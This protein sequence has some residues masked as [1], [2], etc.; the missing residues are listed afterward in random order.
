ML[1]THLECGK[2]WILNL[3]WTMCRNFD[4]E[5]FHIDLQRFTVR[6][7]HSGSS[8]LDWSLN[9]NASIFWLWVQHECWFLLFIN[10]IRWLGYLFT[11]F[12]IFPVYSRGKHDS[13]RWRVHA[14]QF[15]DIFHRWWVC[16]FSALFLRCSLIKNK[17]S[18]LLRSISV[19]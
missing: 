8:R 12:P 5:H 7:C 2:A 18:L 17:I 6:I 19:Y 11:C 16:V 15:C 1:L 4:D 10:Y 9:M 3:K 14:G 13:R